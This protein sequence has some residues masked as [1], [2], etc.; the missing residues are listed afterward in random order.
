VCSGTL[1]RS[2]W[3]E[4]VVAGLHHT[5]EGGAGAPIAVTEF[6]SVGPSAPAPWELVDVVGELARSSRDAA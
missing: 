5:A 2:P 4:V 3:L 1:D 6:H